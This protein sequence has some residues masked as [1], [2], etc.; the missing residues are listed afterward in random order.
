MTTHPKLRAV[1]ARPHEQNGTFYLALHDP[2]ELHEGTL[3]VPEAAAPLLALLNGTTPVERLT[4]FAPRAEIE[5]LLRALDEAGLLDNERAQA[6][7]RSVA[8]AF[9]E[10]PQRTPALAGLSYPAAPEALRESLDGYLAAMQEAASPSANAFH[11]KGATGGVGL[12]SPHIDF[13]R[14]GE[15]Y[16]R[17]WRQFAP[18]LVDADLVIVFATDH[19]GVDPYTL[20]RQRYATPFGP[21]P[22]AVD[23]VDAL[24]AV[25]D[26]E[27]GEGAA[28]AGELRHRKEHSIELVLVWLH[29]MLQ[30]LGRSD[31]PE[32]VPIL[33]GS[34]YPY[35]RNG[36]VPADD[37][38]HARVLAA[39]RE[40]SQGRRT[41]VVASGDLAH[42]GP[43]FGGA[44]VHQPQRD[45]LRQ[46]DG[47]LIETLVAGDER[48]FFEQIRAVRDRNNV[49]GTTPVYHALRL[50]HALHGEHAIEGLPTGYQQCPADARNSSTVSICGVVWG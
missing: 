29:Y 4:A 9:H 32:I 1:D 27:L 50:L 5:G 11:Q 35:I 39:L 22:T 18:A 21:L 20:T 24:A 33:C 40:A 15:T 25:I 12:L 13:A 48:T 10:S 49:C 28:F 7:R 14:G 36:H 19:G 31:A 45:L 8:N 47:A 26:E 42:V 30:K 3:L 17:V 6:A 46:A 41:L 2:E 16:A 23:I 38:L 37:A 44:P 43:A 34:F